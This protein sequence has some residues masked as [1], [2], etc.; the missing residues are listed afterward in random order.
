MR[1]AGDQ[2]GILR[3]AG[4]AAVSCQR[5]RDCVMVTAN[6]TARAGCWMMGILEEMWMESRVD[7][8][9]D[10]RSAPGPMQVGMCCC[11]CAI[12]VWACGRVPC[13]HVGML[14]LGG[15]SRPQH[16]PSDTFVVGVCALRRRS[17]FNALV[18][19]LT[20]HTVSPVAS[21]GAPWRCS[22]DR[23]RRR[24][25]ECPETAH[26]RPA[27][28]HTRVQSSGSCAGPPAWSRTPHPREA[29]R[30]CAP[31]PL[32]QGPS[33]RECSPP[34]RRL[35]GGTV[36]RAGLGKGES[37]STAASWV[38][39][40]SSAA[41]EAT[42]PSDADAPDDR[43]LLLR[44]RAEASWESCPLV[45][46]V[47][48]NALNDACVRWNSNQLLQANHAASEEDEQDGLRVPSSS[49]EGCHSVF[50]ALLLLVGAELQCRRW[51]GQGPRAIIVEW[52]R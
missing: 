25:S 9:D 33:C 32:H 39:C 23:A 11:A 49:S 17:R 18:H 31:L 45:A 43:S 2:R 14:A 28:R 8:Y 35:G 13:W 5:A 48:G 38:N 6:C 12:C 7:K 42:G 26:E 50:L 40:R 21:H 52:L 41:A 51:S 22:S 3:R 10:T 19:L 1:S 29:G 46:L 4:R 16:R 34:T 30:C 27:V 37:A 15:R 20:S 24:P 47:A 44:R 36:V